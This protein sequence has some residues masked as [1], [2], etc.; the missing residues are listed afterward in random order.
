MPSSDPKLVINAYW[1]QYDVIKDVAD[2]LNMYT[3]YEEGDDWDVLWLDGPAF[4]SLLMKMQNHQRVNHFPG[5]NC[6]ARKNMLAKNLNIVK[7]AFP[8][9]YNFFPKTW[10]LPLD[11]K[12]FKT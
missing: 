5:M 11:S 9:E 2:D 6:L 10:I 7:K 12:D 1:T 8:A 3:S 4:P